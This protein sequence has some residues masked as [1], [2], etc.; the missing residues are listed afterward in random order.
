VADAD[1]TLREA[2]YAFRNISHGSTDERKYRARAKKYAKRVVR[3]Y[4]ASIEASQARAILDALDVSYA[5]PGS[6]AVTRPLQEVVTFLKNHSATTG[7]RANSTQSRFPREL[8]TS[9]WRPIMQRFSEL[10][11]NKKKYLAI[12][13]FFAFVFPGGI[14]FM[15]GLAIV[16]ALRPAL[17][18]KHLDH[19]LWLLG[20]E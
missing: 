4:P 7:H 17:L 8:G 16:Y 2:Q 13:L 5:I 14:F 11:N 9:E 20:S 15:G 6:G 12:G 19:L 1:E 3:K 10:P 18:K